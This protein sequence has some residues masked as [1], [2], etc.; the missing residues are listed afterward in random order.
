MISFGERMQLPSYVRVIA[1]WLTAT[2]V[3]VAI[4]GL[5]VWLGVN[6][7]TAGMV[8]L[9]LV[10]WFAAQAGIWLALYVALLC[11]VAFDYFFLLPFRTLQIVGLQQWVAMISFL[12]SCAVVGRVA[13]RA[14]S[15]ARQAEQRRAALMALEMKLYA[16]GFYV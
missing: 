9:V 12:I 14:R 1:S 16:E 4:T 15:Q 5:L 8:F 7:T 11:A 13:E 6:S 2:L 10:V 3:A